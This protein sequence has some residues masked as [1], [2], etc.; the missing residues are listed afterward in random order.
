MRV[1]FMLGM[2]FGCLHVNA[3]SYSQVKQVFKSMPNGGVDLHYD[4]SGAI[5]ATAYEHDIV[6]NAGMVKVLSSRCEVIMVLGHE[7]GHISNGDRGSNKGAEYRADLYGYKMALRSGCVHPE[8]LY[9]KFRAMLGD[10]KS[11]TH[12]SWSERYEN[13]LAY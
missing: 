12:P 13:V 11:K 7:L 9:L 8:N 1:L 4:S 3:M 6:I 10:R 5:N 2:L